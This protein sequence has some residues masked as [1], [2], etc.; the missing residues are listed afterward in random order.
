MCFQR[1]LSEYM[2]MSLS[3]GDPG[4]L[5]ELSVPEASDFPSTDDPDAV[6]SVKVLTLG[7]EAYESLD[8]GQNLF[9]CKAVTQSGERERS[10][11]IINKVPRPNPRRRLPGRFHSRQSRL[12]VQI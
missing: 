11:F 6:Y 9:F 7:P 3:S 8:N 10:P 4:V 12:P 5:V 2:H 1:E